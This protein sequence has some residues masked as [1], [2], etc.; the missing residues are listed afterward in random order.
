M[1]AYS[2]F[3][4]LVAKRFSCRKYAPVPVSRDTMRAV[5]DTARLAPSACNRQP[6][7][8]VVADTPE[9]CRDVKQCYSREWVESVPAFIVACGNH[10]EAWHR[11]EDGKDH[12]DVDVAISVEHICLAAASLGLG[13][14]WICNFDI[15]ALNSALNIPDGVEPIAII[16]VGYPDSEAAAP[17]KK[18]KSIDEIT[19]WGKF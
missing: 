18:R 14:C 9:L 2:Q 6:W 5:L 17:E 13:S 15:A 8:F 11:P 12:T 4:D 7:T 16:A 10:A 1:N 19:Q 3:Y